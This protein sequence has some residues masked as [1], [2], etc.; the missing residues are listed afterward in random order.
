MVKP[1]CVYSFESSGEADEPHLP[2]RN[3]IVEIF[4]R[5]L[6]D[7]NEQQGEENAN[8]PRIGRN[9][10]PLAGQQQRCGHCPDEPGQRSCSGNRSQ[11]RAAFGPGDEGSR[12][13]LL[14]GS[15]L[16]F[17]LKLLSGIDDPSQLADC[18]LPIA[19]FSDRGRAAEPSCQ[20]AFSKTGARFID[21]LKERALSE[22]VQVLR[23]KV[24]W[25]SIL[26]SALGEAV[27]LSRQPSNPALV[28]AREQ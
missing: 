26:V 4:Q 15:D 14:L 20:D 27:P 24:I 3:A 19:T 12:V 13:R 5:T 17:E 1:L 16:A 10:S 28:Q 9:Q 25:L 23:V 18:S 11:I 8:Q 21:Q 6:S 2:C 22:D 7:R